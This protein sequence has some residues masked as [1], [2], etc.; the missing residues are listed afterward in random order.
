MIFE[1]FSLKIKGK[2]R[3]FRLKMAGRSYDLANVRFPR[4][5]PDTAPGD[6]C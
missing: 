4:S 1:G 3:G 6:R 5:C 2:L